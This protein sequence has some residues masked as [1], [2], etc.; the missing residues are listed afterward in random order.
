MALYYVLGTEPQTSYKTHIWYMDTENKQL[1]EKLC[2]MTYMN[3]L[4]PV[5][6][7]E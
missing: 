5:K 6:K 3:K 4:I 1:K 2:N 7:K